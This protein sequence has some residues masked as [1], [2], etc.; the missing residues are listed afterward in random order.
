[1]VLS[2]ICLR[3]FA[4]VILVLRRKWLDERNATLDKTT[5]TLWICDWGI[6][7]RFQIRPFSEVTLVQETSD[8]KEVRESLD[9]EERARDE[10]TNIKL[11]YVIC[12]DYLRSQLWSLMSAPLLPQLV[13]NHMSKEIIALVQSE[14]QP[15]FA[16][17]PAQDFV[18]IFYIVESVHVQPNEYY[19]I[20]S[21]P[22][23]SQK[24]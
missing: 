15:I 23:P 18:T 6:C 17:T 19:E 7:Y 8:K 11:A 4:R 2:A 9:T 10:N 1:M 22:T 20:F 12:D 5:N 3:A 13:I 14:I 21:L 16:D 24:T